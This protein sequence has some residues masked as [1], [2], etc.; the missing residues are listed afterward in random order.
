MRPGVI[1]I[2]TGGSV[3]HTMVAQCVARLEPPT[4]SRVEWVSGDG[5]IAANRNY[6]CEALLMTDGAWLWLL[7][8]D[9]LFAPDCL[10][11]LLCHLDRPNVDVVVPLVL[12]RRPPHASTLSAISQ[13]SEG[14][15]LQH[16]PIQVG[17]QGL[18]PVD[19]AGAGG[20]L[21]RRAVL[22]R[23]TRPWF[24]LG[25]VRSDQLH[26]DTW[27]C[28]KARDAGFHVH[29]DLDTPMGHIAQF[30]V[31]PHRVIVQG[32]P[33]RDV[34][35]QFVRGALGTLDEIEAAAAAVRGGVENC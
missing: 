16:R 23:L 1:A 6:A 33:R 13:S 18:I 15:A 7:D 34:V 30:A 24:E 25:R 9:Q 12:R 21:I 32:Q 19:A 31:W 10:R 26:E 27:F 22:E 11:R 5:N 8:D 3:R 20:M 35:H 2:V 28:I 4:G 29:A 14:F 17:E